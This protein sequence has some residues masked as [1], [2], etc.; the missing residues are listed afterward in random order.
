MLTE[1]QCSRL[2][3][4]IAPLK[5]SWSWRESSRPGNAHVG[6]AVARAAAGGLRGCAVAAEGQQAP[7]GACMMA[8]SRVAGSK[9]DE[10]QQ[11][12]GDRFGLI[13]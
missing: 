8:I 7:L 3:H 1:S 5:A 9:H 6:S 4:S 2:G 10:G 11:H 12:C 13:V